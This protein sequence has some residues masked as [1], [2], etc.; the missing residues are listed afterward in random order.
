MSNITSAL[1]LL[2]TLAII[3]AFLF[4]GIYPYIQE[5]N[6]SLADKLDVWYKIAQVLV[7]DEATKT[8]KSG[9]DKKQTATE[10]LIDQ[11]KNLKVPL[12]S[13]VAAGLIQ[14]AYNQTQANT[15]AALPDTLGFVSNADYQSKTTL[16]RD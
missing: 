14:T 2:S 6:K 16:G 8:D 15:K 7:N 9:T 12:D 10:T 4:V 3:I 11:A 13:K 1:Q 5:H